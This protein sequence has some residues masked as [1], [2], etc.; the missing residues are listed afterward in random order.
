LTVDYFLRTPPGKLSKL[1][2]LVICIVM[3][4]LSLRTRQQDEPAPS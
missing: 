4:G 2:L 1:P 3:L